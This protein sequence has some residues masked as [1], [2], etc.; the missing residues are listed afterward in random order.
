MAVRARTNSHENR[1][2]Q[3]RRRTSA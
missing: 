1:P 3:V 2:Q